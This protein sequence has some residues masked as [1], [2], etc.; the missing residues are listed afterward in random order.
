MPN[1]QQMPYGILPL[2]HEDEEH[3]IFIVKA[4]KEYI[5]AAK[6]KATLA[7]YLAPVLI[8]NQNTFGLVTA[9]FDDEDEPLVIKTPLF[10][11]PFCVDLFKSLRAG[12]LNVHFFDELSRELLAYRA[13]VTIPV[14]TQH[15]IDEMIL[16][17]FSFPCT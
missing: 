4:P 16:L 15:K 6:I 5:L 11:D 7:I 17:D 13:S 2:C 14:E 9:F 12:R 3:P 1:I 8:D 10:S